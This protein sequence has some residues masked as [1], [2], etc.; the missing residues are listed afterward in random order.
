MDEKEKDIKRLKQLEA[1]KKKQFAV[2][3]KYSDDILKK[4]KKVVKSIILFGSVIRGDVH[5]K[6]DIDIL[7]VIDDTLARFTPEM[8][9]RFDDDLHRLAKKIN[10]QITVQPAWT[11]TEFW[12]MARIGHPLLYTIVRD[13]WALY[14]TGFFIPVRKLLELGKIPTTLE[15]VEKFME[16]APQKINR[17]ETAKLFM[18]AEDLYYAMLNSSQAILMY[19]GREPAAPKHTPREV[20]EYLVKENILETNYLEDLRAVIDFRKGVEH[21]DIKE[22]SGVDLDNYIQK[23][24][25]FVSRMEQLL[26]QLQKKKKESIIHKN[27]EV[28]IKAAVAALKRLDKLPEDPK[29]LSAAIK[30]NLIDAGRV[31]SY[32]GDVFRRVVTMRKL[33]DDNKIDEVPQRDLELTREYVRRFVRD[34]EPILN[35]KAKVSSKTKKKIEGKT[36]KK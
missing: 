9:E 16:T 6:S 17:V 27:Y 18:I 22:V 14:D 25:Q 19:V 24:K 35:V 11:L 36:K 2:A 26:M 1:L 13:G 5:E 21:K 7:V 33:L 29:N 12:D 20:E 34:L 31:D 30:D 23:S 4:Y 10:D 28:M 3:N 15:S 8:K 32:F